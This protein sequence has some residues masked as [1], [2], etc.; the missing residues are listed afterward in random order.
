MNKEQ[1]KVKMLKE[2]QEL[3][4]KT[5]IYPNRNTFNGLLYCILGL[6]GESGEVTEKVK[7]IMRDQNGII[8]QVDKKEIEKELGDALWYLSQ[9]CSELKLNLE[10]VAKLNIEKLYSRK[11]RDVLHG[12]GDNR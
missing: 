4:N 8:A 3:A 2:Y 1:I 12:N 9:I 6:N 7:K 10:D 5:A 11:E